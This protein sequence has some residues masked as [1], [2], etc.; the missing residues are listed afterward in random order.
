[1]EE[2]HQT[3]REEYGLKAAGI[4]TS[5]EKFSTLFGLELGYLVLNSS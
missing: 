2:I 4:L 5:L 1:M 3:S